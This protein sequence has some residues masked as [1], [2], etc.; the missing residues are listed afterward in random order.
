[1]KVAKVCSVLEEFNVLERI[2]KT[3]ISTCCRNLGK[4]KP[5]VWTFQ[6]T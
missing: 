6:A 5:N 1:M 3:K 4:H 2:N